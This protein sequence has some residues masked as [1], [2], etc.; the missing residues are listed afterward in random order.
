[1]FIFSDG[2]L[3]RIRVLRFLSGRHDRFEL[4][5]GTPLRSLNRR[6]RGLPGKLLKND[7]D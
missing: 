3:F 7:V 2:T 5:T 6:N 4:L 1:M